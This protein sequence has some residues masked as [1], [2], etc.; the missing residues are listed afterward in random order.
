MADLQ[1]TLESIE[2]RLARLS[3]IENALIEL[4]GEVRKILPPLQELDVL[5]V[6]RDFGKRGPDALKEWN[7]RQKLLRSK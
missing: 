7:Q 4:Q 6:A 1:A 3:V 2:E 5:T